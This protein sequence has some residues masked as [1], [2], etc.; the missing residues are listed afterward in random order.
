MDTTKIKSF[1][2]ARHP[3]D[4]LTDEERELIASRMSRRQ[5]AKGE[6]LVEVGQMVPG[7]HI[8]ES[9]HVEITSPEGV[10]ISVVHVGDAFGERGML[11][12]GRAPVTA[13]CQEDGAFLLL[14]CGEFLRLVNSVEAFAEFFDRR[15]GRSAEKARARGPDIDLST[16]RLSDIMTRDPIGVAPDETIESAARLMRDKNISCLLVREGDSLAGIM[17]TGDLTNRLVTR[18]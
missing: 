16:T 8:V 2:D 14:P 6:V 13:T 11:R 17:T 12:D 15:S 10:L 3:F 7:L 1:L 4:V 5:M 9:G 18:L